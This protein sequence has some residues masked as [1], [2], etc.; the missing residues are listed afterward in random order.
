MYFLSGI[1]YTYSAYQVVSTVI[2]TGTELL[3]HLYTL[4]GSPLSRGATVEVSSARI[5]E[6]PGF[7][8]GS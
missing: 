8:P 5:V 2:R 4:A 7:E 6:H 1:T 3:S